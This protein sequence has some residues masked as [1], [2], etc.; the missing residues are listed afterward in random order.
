[1][2]RAKILE[3][4]RANPKDWRIDEI[5]VIAKHF[6]IKVYKSGGSH[7][8]LKHVRWIEMLCIPAHRPIKPIYIKKLLHLLNK[9]GDDQ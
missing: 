9:L 3:K 2:K 5:E 8:V 1:M 6:N 4:M 7:V